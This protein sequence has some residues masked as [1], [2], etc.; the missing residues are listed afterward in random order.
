MKIYRERMVHGSGMAD[1][2]MELVLSWTIY[3][4]VANSNSS[5]DK[6][7]A[8]ENSDIHENRKNSWIMIET[9]V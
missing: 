7:T 5:C 9:N 6:I 4:L 2:T 8:Y 1:G 3:A